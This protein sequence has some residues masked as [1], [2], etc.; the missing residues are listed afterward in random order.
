MGGTSIVYLTKRTYSRVVT[1]PLSSLPD[2]HPNV[3]PEEMTEEE[4]TALFGSPQR[5][6]REL[7]CLTTQQKQAEAPDKE[8][9]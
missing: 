8:R 2:F 5:I 4:L 1:S 3:P 7:A 6:V 9:K